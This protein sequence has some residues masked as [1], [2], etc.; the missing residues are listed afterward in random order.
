V[1]LSFTSED[2]EN[3][4]RFYRGVCEDGLNQAMGI[5]G[6]QFGIFLPP[7]RVL[8]TDDDR[9]AHRM[10]ARIWFVAQAFHYAEQYVLAREADNLDD[11][12]RRFFDEPDP[13]PDLDP[14]DPGDGGG[15][16]VPTR[17]SPPPGW[18]R[19]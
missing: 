2:Q 6:G 8:E 14:P 7:A 10:I 17:P 11:D 1:E 18:T 13:P 3:F 12:L 16:P 19:T 4:E 9:A 15:P 5:P